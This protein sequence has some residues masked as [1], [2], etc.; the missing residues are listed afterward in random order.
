MLLAA[1]H[2]TVMAYGIGGM[3]AWLLVVAVVLFLQTVSKRKRDRRRSLLPALTPTSSN[4][5]PSIGA[6]M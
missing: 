5:Y 2:K 4:S 3:S 6:H 1:V